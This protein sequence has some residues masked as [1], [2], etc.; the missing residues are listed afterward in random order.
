MKNHANFRLYGS[1][2]DFLPAAKKAIWISYEFRGRPAVKDA[3]EALGIPHPEVHAILA[4][5]K[6]VD[7][8][9]PLH[10]QEQFEVYPAEITPP[11]PDSY[12]LRDKYLAV[13]KFILDVHLGKLAKTLRML[14]FDCFYENEQSDQAIAARAEKENRIVLTRDVGL[15]KYKAIRWGYW[16]RSQN[17]T[18]QLEEVIRHFKLQDSYKPFSRCLACNGLIEEVAKESVLDYIPPRT[19]EYFHDF[20]QC[21]SCKKVYWKGSHYERMQALLERIASDERP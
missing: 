12:L 20:F 1:L 19:K 6:A 2:N 4:N 3:I 11:L 5:K 13:K 8:A 16:L 7:F 10:P 17:P 9:Y 21:L 15:L 14:G 18:E